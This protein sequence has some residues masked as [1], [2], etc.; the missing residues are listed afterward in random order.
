MPIG[1]LVFPGHNHAY[2]NRGGRYPA[3]L[4]RTSREHAP[5]GGAEISA[6]LSSKHFCD[7]AAPREKDAQKYTTIRLHATRIA[8]LWPLFGAEQKFA[9]YK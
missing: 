2:H 4:R 6:Q 7:Q 8:S 1:R 9:P 3:C 5:E